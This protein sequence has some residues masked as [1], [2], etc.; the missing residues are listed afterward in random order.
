MQAVLGEQAV[1]WLSRGP[2]SSGE[3]WIGCRRLILI[4][5]LSKVL[6]IEEVKGPYM[7][8]NQRL[9]LI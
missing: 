6:I 2:D 1:S 3:A 5:K 4:L 8:P 9:I 7:H